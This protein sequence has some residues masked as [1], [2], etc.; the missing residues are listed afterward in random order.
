MRIKRT[1]LLEDPEGILGT[2]TELSTAQPQ[3]VSSASVLSG[4][5]PDTRTC[6]GGVR[7]CG[8]DLVLWE[9]RGTF[10]GPLFWGSTEPCMGRIAILP[11]LLLC[12]LDPHTLAS[13]FLGGIPEVLLVIPG[14]GHGL[15][16]GERVT[17]DL[18]AVAS[19]LGAVDRGVAA[20]FRHHRQ[21][22]SPS[23]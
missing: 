18:G 15:S 17:L 12:L 4:E 23:S 16:G 19:G 7:G 3:L 5:R 21:A 20:P 1:D 13:I 14:R 10:P 22:S 6:G 2:D 9:G 11:D 8:L